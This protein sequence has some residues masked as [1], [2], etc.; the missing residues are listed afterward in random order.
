M[1]KLICLLTALF[2][3]T[4]CGAPKDEEV[5]QPIA[6]ENPTET[7]TEAP[8]NEPVPEYAY[9]SVGFGGMTDSGRELTVIL[10]YKE[11]EN[12]MVITKAMA[13]LSVAE[14]VASGAIRTSGTSMLAYNIDVVD[15]AFS[16]SD[17]VGTIVDGVAIGTV[18]LSS[19]TYDYTA[20][21]DTVENCEACL[22]KGTKIGAVYGSTAE[23]CSFCNGIG[24]V[25]K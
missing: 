6:T 25:L 24:L 22:G 18:V 5:V 13:N 14:S 19:V 12:E 2:L 7:P 15:G 16:Q 21:A 23:N 1:K 10:R 8:T 9:Y 4:A 3:L 11:N 20:T 17:F